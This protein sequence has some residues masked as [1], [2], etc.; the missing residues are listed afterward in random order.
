MEKYYSQLISSKSFPQATMD[1]PKVVI[2]L[3]EAHA[4]H[5]NSQKE[6]SPADVFLR[7]IKEYSEAKNTAVW[8][9]FA[10][11]TSKVAHLASPRIKT[12]LVPSAR[13]AVEGQ[14]LFP[15]FTQLGW[16]QNAPVLK[17]VQRDEVAKAGHILQYG[18]PL[19]ASLK[20]GYSLEDLLT[21]AAQKLC[22]S[23][24]FNPEN[25]DQ[26]F[27]VLAQRFGLDIAFGHRDAVRYVET[28]VASHLRFCINTTE[29]RIWSYSTYP[30]EP[31]L[32][33]AAASLLLDDNKLDPTL[34]SLESMVN[35]GVVDISQIGELVSRFLWLLA[36]DFFV[37]SELHV[38]ND[39]EPQFDQELQDCRLISVVEFLRSVFGPKMWAENTKAEEVFQNAYI[40]FSHWVS[41]DSNIRR[42]KKGLKQL[43]I[44]KW[45]LCHWERTSAVQC[46]HNQP[47]IDKVIPMYFKPQNAGE[48]RDTRVS[49]ILISDKARIS[50][51]KVDLKDIQ[52]DHPSIAPDYHGLPYIAILVDLGVDKPDF[53]VSL[54]SSKDRDTCLRIYASGLDAT[55]YPFLVGRDKVAVTLKDLYKRQ[56]APSSCGH[57]QNLEDQVRFGAS[58][59]P[60]SMNL[61]TRK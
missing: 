55:T 38:T 57:L 59:E 31:I 47:L 20:G 24:V 13:F 60:R 52:R 19:W 61:K 48:R 18:R 30:S 45:T 17:A 1:E 22:G 37:R 28:S 12:I 11:T 39:A 6:F 29:D 25:E 15:P 9:V 46:C 35:D 10:S 40:N 33:C 26:A 49:H 42:D 14:L 53:D 50:P 2:A 34:Q 56:S 27:A 36:K 43:S 21:L 58:S 16:D 8:V 32:S 41:M 5:D 7:T 54:D 44:E 4:L 23:E 3:D 51:Q